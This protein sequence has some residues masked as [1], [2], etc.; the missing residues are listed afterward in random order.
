[1]AEKRKKSWSSLTPPY[2]SKVLSE[3][4]A[5]FVPHCHH[6]SDFDQFLKQL[7]QKNCRDH[8]ALAASSSIL[9][10]A[11]D[12]KAVIGG[13]AALRAQHAER[14][15]HHPS[16]TVNELDDV[17]VHNTPTRS[18]L[19]NL[20]YPISRNHYGKILRKEVSLQ[21]VPSAS[22]G[23]RPSLV[24]SDDAIA[25]VGKVV[26][27]HT[28]ESERVVV[29][30][31][32]S[33]KR[34]VVANHLTKTK[35]RLWCEIEALHAAMSWESF[36]IRKVLQIHF[37]HMRNSR[38]NTDVCSHCKTF[39]KDLLPAAF[40]SMER[41]QALLSQL[42]PNYFQE[43]DTSQ[44]DKVRILEQ[45][46]SFV[47]RREAT[48]SQD[49]LR[50]G[51]TRAD[52]LALHSA[53][54]QALHRLKP[55]VEIVQA[56]E[57]H[58][59]SARR[60]GNFVASMCSK[61]PSGTALL[62]VDFKE[63]I[64]YPMGPDETS[65]EW[66]AQNKLSLTVFGAN[67][68]VPTHG[69]GSKEFFILVT[70]DILDH[71]AQVDCMMVSAV[72]SHLCPRADVDWGSVNHLLIVADCG[73]HF[74][75]EENLAHF[76]VALPM[77]LRMFVEVCW[78]VE[79]HGNPGYINR[80]PIHSLDDLIKCFT[81]GSGRMMA[82]DPDGPTIPLVQFAPGERRPSKRL[83]VSENFKISRTYLLI[84]SLSS[85][86]HH[87]AMIRNKT[88]SD[89]SPGDVLS[90]S[91]ASKTFLLKICR[92]GEL[93]ATTSLVLGNSQ[94]LK[95]AKRT[96]LLAD[97]ATKRQKRP[98]TCRTEG[99]PFC[100]IALTKVFPCSALL[101]RNAA[102]S[103]GYVERNLRLLPHLLHLPPRLLH[104]RMKNL[105]DC[106][107]RAAAKEKM[108]DSV[109]AESTYQPSAEAET[110]VAEAARKTARKT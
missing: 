17:L 79:Q 57:W 28:F 54:A 47:A 92:L 106:R 31:H 19:E 43:L 77:T 108:L 73:P 50:Q 53:E 85:S 74:R 58:Q 101:Q 63:N 4:V 37:P 21:K 33:K 24:N 88:F 93:D 97:S 95:Q 98:L 48:A 32:G 42:C 110:V 6:E 22:L 78:L 30:G 12:A 3:S 81:E 36:R 20:G 68:S 67:A 56:Y 61:L 62:H 27:E 84:G 104:R 18:T 69:G 52:R 60:Q 71:D 44:P 90:Y 15:L 40:R 25:A 26:E 2:R 10:N 55:H 46:Y 5:S 96:V 9:L 76:C 102:R 91:I 14:T 1:M 51:F 103:R 34:M 86:A 16:I 38:R 100:K 11:L 99:Q 35:H 23:G 59:V 80:A 94:E 64:K 7:L 66:H 87:G 65:E 83:L 41:A 107:A 75:S 109:E 45:F 8:S 29:V 89:L 13:L 82:Q 105:S 72:L 49:P 70:T 39:E